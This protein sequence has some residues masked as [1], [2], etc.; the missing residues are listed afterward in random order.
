MDVLPA[1][2]IFV[3]TARI[4]ITLLKVTTNVINM[5]HESNPGVLVPIVF[6]V[7][8]IFTALVLTDVYVLSL[9]AHDD[10]EYVV[11]RATS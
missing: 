6:A 5:W 9:L 8:I 2:L 4:M 1:L 11:P 10:F 7:I 3:A